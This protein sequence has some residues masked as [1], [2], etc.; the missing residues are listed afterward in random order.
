MRNMR[1]MPIRVAERIALFGVF[2][3]HEPERL[4]VGRL[5][6]RTSSEAHFLLRSLHVLNRL[7]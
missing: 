5:A 2:R 7:N 3:R 4:T 1:A 6:L